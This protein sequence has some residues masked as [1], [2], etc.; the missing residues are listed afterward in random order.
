MDDL[1]RRALS[2]LWFGGITIVFAA[3]GYF[4][5]GKIGAIEGAVIGIFLGHGA[6][7]GVLRS[8]REERRKHREAERPW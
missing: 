7:L 3:V 1:T 4:T 2:P 5:G 6:L 8:E